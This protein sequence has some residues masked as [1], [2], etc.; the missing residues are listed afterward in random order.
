MDKRYEKKI[1]ESFKLIEHY[2][3]T[4]DLELYEKITR[5]VTQIDFIKIYFERMVEIKKEK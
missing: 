2:K 5:I 4:D 1:S 3:K